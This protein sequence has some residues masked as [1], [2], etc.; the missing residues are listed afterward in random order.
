MADNFSTFLTVYGGYLG[1]WVN[2]IV[3]KEG[4]YVLLLVFY[5]GMW[6]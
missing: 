4:G 5:S 1:K 6:V 2:K 3:R